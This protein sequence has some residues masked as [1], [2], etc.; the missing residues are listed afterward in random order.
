LSSATRD[1]HRFR[2]LLDRASDAAWNMAVDE[3]LLD[4]YAEA[5]E[6]LPPTLRLYAWV[7]AALSLG[8]SQ[9]GPGSCD[10]A[11]L[12][13]KGIDLVR[14]PTGGQA[15]LHEH[16]R[17]YALVGQLGR[18]P[19]PAGVGEIYAEVSRALTA[20]L[21]GLGLPAEASP[22]STRGCRPVAG[23]SCFHRTGAH[24][25]SVAGRKL[26]GSAQLRR[27][28]AF[29]QHGSILIRC[30]PGQV[31][32]A[33]GHAPRSGAFTDLERE[34]GRPLDPAELDRE[35]VR[36]FERTFSACLCEG[37]LSEPEQVRAT[38]YR[39]WKYLS[40]G[41]TLDGRA[42]AAPPAPQV[43]GSRAEPGDHRATRCGPFGRPGPSTAPR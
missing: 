41:W 43:T 37:G 24:E 12:R 30:D 26:V 9:P 7:P 19:F 25:I 33:I 5:N 31:A 16:E 14:R 34:L 23:A 10:L 36:A 11:Y 8:R 15:V 13:E 28:G 22:A 1:R 38:W 20:A 42:P 39:A 40:A 18:P 4:H 6:P 17:T 32:R 27:R 35:L 2:L 29:L 3:A 21:V